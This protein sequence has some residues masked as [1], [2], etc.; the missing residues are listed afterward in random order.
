[1]VV[2]GVAVVDAAGVDEATRVAQTADLSNHFAGAV[3][4]GPL[5]PCGHGAAPAR[6]RAGAVL[7]DV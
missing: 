2:P 5:D 3:S 1:M 7:R 6:R 4:G